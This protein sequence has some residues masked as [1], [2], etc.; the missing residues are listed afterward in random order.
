MKNLP[1]EKAKVPFHPDFPERGIREIKLSKILFV[2]KEDFE[3][4]R[5]REVGL[6]YLGTVKLDKISEFISQEVNIKLPKIQWVPERFVEIEIFMPNGKIVKGIGEPGLL[7]TKVDD[8]IQ[9]VRIGFCRVDEIKENKV[10]LFFAH[11]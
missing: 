6:I 5:G 7:N 9:L 8:I 10:I 11:K 2:E 3:K 4:L 1:L